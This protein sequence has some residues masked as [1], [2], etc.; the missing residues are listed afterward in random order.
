MCIGHDRLTDVIGIDCLFRPLTEG[1]FETGLIELCVKD[2]IR[3]LETGRIQGWANQFQ[4]CRVKI[5]LGE[6]KAV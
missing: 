2:Y 6:F 4:I 5:R 3:K 1:E